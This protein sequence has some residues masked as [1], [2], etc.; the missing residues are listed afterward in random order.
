MN[1]SKKSQYAVL[2]ALSIK[3]MSGYEIMKLMAGST[4][5]FWAESNGQLYPTLAELAKVK[6]ITVKNQVTGTKKRKIYTLTKAGEKKLK[7]WLIKDENSFSR[8]DELLLKLFYGA[9]V[10]PD[11]SIKHINNHITK[12]KV[13]LETYTD[14]AKNLEELVRQKQHPV[15]YLLTVRAGIQRANAELEW[16]KEAIKLIKKYNEI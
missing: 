2:G 12:C 3:P 6:L 15:Y 8:R 1:K 13:A 7:E 11:I 5:Y 4:N 16:S 9:N 14:I 10:S